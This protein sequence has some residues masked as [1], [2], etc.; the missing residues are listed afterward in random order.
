MSDLV[1]LAARIDEIWE[2]GAAADARAVVSE[3][4]ALLDAGAIRVAEKVDGAWHVNEWVKKAVLLHFRYSDNR[5]MTAGP[6][7]WFDKVALKTGWREAGVRSVP[8]AI[9]RYGSFIEPGAVLMPSYVNIGARVGTGTM[10]DTWSTVGS[11]AQ[12]GKNC[13]ISGGVGIGGVLEPL[14][15]SPVIIEDNVFLGARGEVA[16]GVLI[17]EGA[18]LAM[19]CFVAGSTKIYSVPE[20][21]ELP[22]GRIP[23]RSVCVPGSL[24]SKD[25]SHSTYAIIIKKLRDERTDARTALNSLL[26]EGGV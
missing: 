24:L 8:T 10:I 5:E 4:L 1:T 7:E 20:G 2:S 17:E 15:A 25:G 6:I 26:R 12:V 22:P 9:A 16:E 13:H 18:V 19:G 21:R 11:C 3:A 23:A 14:Q